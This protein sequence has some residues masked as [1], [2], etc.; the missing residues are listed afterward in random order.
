MCQMPMKLPAMF[1]QNPSYI[2]DKIVKKRKQQ[3]RPNAHLLH[4]VMHYNGNII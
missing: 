2:F 1:G 4:I 3:T